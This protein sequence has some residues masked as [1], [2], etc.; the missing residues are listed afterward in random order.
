MY[1]EKVFD[2]GKYDFIGKA[3]YIVPAWTLLMFIGIFAIGYKGLNYGIDFAGG[4]EIQVQFQ[5]SVE[6]EMVRKTTSD[7]GYHKASVQSFGDNNEFL[8]RMEAIQGKD[9]KET[10]EL[11]LAMI[12]KVTEGL[13]ENIKDNVLEIRRVD[14]VGPQVGDELKRNSILA[15]FYSLLMILIYIGI[16]FDYK[17]APGAVFCLLH[18]AIIM[19]AIY[20]VFEREVNVQTMAAILALIGHSLNDTIVNFDRIREN[21]HIHKGENFLKIV[22]RSVNDML[23]RTILTSVA[24]ELAVIALYFLSDGVIQQIAFTLGIGIVLGTY[25]SIYIASPLVIAVDHLEQKRA[26]ARMRTVKA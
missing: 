21:E 6:A 20:A 10:N 18:D 19:V 4:T 25:S 1:K 9:D 13:K 3:K 16:R 17:Y 22:N 5:N 11:Q 15:T 14:S 8:L 12:T 2:A 26:R 24:T 23:S 7:L